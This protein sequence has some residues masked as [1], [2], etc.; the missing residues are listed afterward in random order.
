[1]VVNSSQNIR[2]QVARDTRINPASLSSVHDSGFGKELLKTLSTQPDGAR[3]EVVFNFK[4]FGHSMAYEVVQGKPYIFDTQKAIKYDP[5]NLQDMY[6]KWGSPTNA[7]I[8][9]LDNADLDLKFLSRWAT[10]HKG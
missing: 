9:R 4:Q 1:M 5:S 2:G 6:H 10:N 8:T 3:G 7:E